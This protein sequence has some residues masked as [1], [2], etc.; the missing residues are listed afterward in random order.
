[1]STTTIDDVISVTDDP[2]RRHVPDPG[3]YDSVSAT[4]SEAEFRAVELAEDSLGGLWHGEPGSVSSDSWPYTEFCV[5][6]EGRVAVVDA[7]GGRREFGAGD[8][9]VV[10]RGFRGTWETIEPSR[11][12]FVGMR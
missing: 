12:Y 8:A 4:W 11:K 2:S 6:I 5:M 7:E 1:M 10:P 3:E 9:F